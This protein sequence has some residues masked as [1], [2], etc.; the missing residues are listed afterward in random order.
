MPYT[1]GGAT[2]PS[3]F[4]LNNCNNPVESIPDASQIV[5]IQ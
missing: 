1:P 5:E 4:A 3:A 2:A